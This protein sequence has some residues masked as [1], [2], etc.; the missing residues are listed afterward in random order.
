MIYLI[1]Y[2]VGGMGNTIFAHAMYACN[3]INLDLDT[4]FSATGNAHK[5]RKNYLYSQL[6]P[7]HIIEQPQHVPSNSRCIIE[8]KSSLW[9]KLL[10]IKMGYDKFLGKT[11]NLTNVLDFFTINKLHVDYDKMWQEFYKNFKDSSWPICNTYNDIQYLEINIQTEIHKNY[12]HP[13]MDVTDDNWL[14]LLTFAY[15]DV[16]QIS[17]DH[18]SKFGGDTFLLDDYFSSKIDVIKNQIS[19]HLKWKWDDQKSMI[20]Q[21]HVLKKNQI[22]TDW[23]AGLKKIFDKTIDKQIVQIT[24]P[25]WEKSLL[26]ATFC[27][28]CNK[29]PT[30][31]PWDAIDKLNSN[32]E[33]ITIF[34]D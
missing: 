5:I 20:F 26:I 27:A 9:Y 28:L 13:E 32:K 3:K 10:E 23:L 16:L 19:S 6:F 7:L 22:Y 18:R 24:L 33:L 21:Q 8:V 1:D 30:E 29:D 17:K 4:F 25:P 11:P 34:K 2:R 12:R 15:Y 31:L 14:S